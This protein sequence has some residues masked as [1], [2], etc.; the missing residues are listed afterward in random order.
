VRRILAELKSGKS[1]I[2]DFTGTYECKLEFTK[3]NKL[4]TS[5]SC[6]TMAT[7]QAPVPKKGHDNRR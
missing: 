2:L 7:D 6:D 1:R 3:P 4:H 5:N